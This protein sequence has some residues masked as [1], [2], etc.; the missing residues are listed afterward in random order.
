MNLYILKSV[1]GGHHYIGITKDIN[2]R[3]S[4]HNAREVKSTRAYAPWIV[5]YTERY[6]NKIDAR[7]R[8]LFLKRTAKARTDLFAKIDNGP[9]V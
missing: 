7:K 6:D 2:N 5:V 8:E 9:I 1:C 4:E 3:L